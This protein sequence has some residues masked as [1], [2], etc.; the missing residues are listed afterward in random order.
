MQKFIFLILFCLISVFSYP[1]RII[2]RDDL[3]AAQ[4]IIIIP[5]SYAQISLAKFIKLRPGEYKKNIGIRLSLKEALA[6]KLVQIK[7]KKGLKKGHFINLSLSKIEPRKKPRLLVALLIVLGIT[8]LVL[9]IFF[10][11]GNKLFS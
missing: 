9:G 4:I 10:I 2:S 11:I 5:G 6:L 1:A 7:I 3:K 8:V